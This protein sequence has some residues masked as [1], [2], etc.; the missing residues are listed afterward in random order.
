MQKNNQGR[1]KIL[2]GGAREKAMLGELVALAG[3][4]SLVPSTYIRQFTTT[5][6]SSSGR[7]DALWLWGYLYI[8][9]MYIHM[10]RHTCIHTHKNKDWKDGSAV[11]TL[12]ALAKRILVQFSAPIWQ[13][14]TIC[15]S[16]SKKLDALF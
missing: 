15:N 10:L 2:V 7:S 11:R 5:C 9:T 1:F 6:N 13:L 12:V 8:H 14:T 3:D 16:S 4:L